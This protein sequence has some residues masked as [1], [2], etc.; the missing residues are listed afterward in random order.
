MNLLSSYV[1][2]DLD[3]CFF[4][5]QQK[6]AQ[7]ESNVNGDLHIVAFTAVTQRNSTPTMCDFLYQIKLCIIY[8]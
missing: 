4:Q 3:H 2:V 1:E 6:I 7:K 8:Y 5:N